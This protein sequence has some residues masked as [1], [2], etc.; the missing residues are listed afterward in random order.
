MTSPTENHCWPDFRPGED[1]TVNTPA[2]LDGHFFYIC[3][4]YRSSE[5]HQ[6]F[7][8]E[9]F[10]VD[11]PMEEYFLSVRYERGNFVCSKTIKP[12]VMSGKSDL[13]GLGMIC[14]TEVDSSDLFLKVSRNFLPVFVNEDK[15]LEFTYKLFR[16]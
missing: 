15:Q 6:Y 4:D 10:Y 14:K 7:T 12:I 1:V 2:F 13:D 8:L 3:R 5:Q 16:N 9:A 11:K